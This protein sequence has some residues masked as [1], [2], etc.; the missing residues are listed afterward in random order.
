[1]K[2]CSKN[3]PWNLNFI[4]RLYE[5]MRKPYTK[6]KNKSYGIFNMR[7]EKSTDVFVLP[8][9]TKVTFN[10]KWDKHFQGLIH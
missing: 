7:K 3:V 4:N 10:L 5:D 2:N 1:M 6:S 9:I 8:V